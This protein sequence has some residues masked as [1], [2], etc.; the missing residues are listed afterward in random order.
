MTRRVIKAVGLAMGMAGM[1]A[2]AQPSADGA[3]EMVLPGLV[4]TAT[5]T[6]QAPR[7]VPASIDVISGATVRMMGPQVNLSEPLQRIP[8][9]G[10][11]N[12]QNYAQDLQ[13]SSRGFGARSAFGVRGV[14]LYADGIPATMPDGQG[15]SALF[16]L[17]SAERIEVL[18][19]PAS[20]LYGNASGGVVQVFTEDGPPRPEVSTGLTVSRDGFHREQIKLGGEL[21]ALNYVINASH[22]ETDGYRDHSSAQRDQ[23]NTKL[24]WSFADRATLSVVASY[25]NM[26]EVEDPLGLTAEQWRTAPSS[27]VPNA[28]LYNTRKSIENAQLG[29]VYQRPMRGGDDT[30]M[31]MVYHG[32]RQVRQY[33]SIPAGS[34][35]GSH[36]GGVIDFS[37][38]YAG[39]DARYT[40][41]H[42]AL[43]RP[44]EITAGV[45]LDEMREDRQGYR[46]FVDDGGGEATLGVLGERR[47]DEDNIAR[48]SD[49]YLQ[50]Q[51][52]VSDRWVLSAGVRHSRVRFES[53]D[54]FISGDNGDDSGQALWSATTPTVSALFKLSP[55]WHWYATAGRSFE[56]PTLNETAYRSVNGSQP[57]LNF[58]LRPSTAEH[59]ELGFKAE[60]SEGW[61]LSA[62]A[63]QVDTDDEIGVSSSE[64]GRTVYRNVGR[65]SRHGLEMTAQW[66]VNR[67][68]TAYA[69]LSWLSAHYQ[70]AFGA[71][72]AAVRAGNTLP[73]LPV[74][75]AFA[76]LAWRPATSWHAALELRHSSRVWANDA[77]TEYAPAWTTWAARAGWRHISGDWRLDTLARIDNLNNERYVGS[78]IVNDRSSRY[79]EPAPGRALTV[80]ATLTRAF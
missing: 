4:V 71:G 58:A 24:R 67:A 5:R 32:T 7:D 54:H 43:S 37:R 30:L 77:N 64:Q 61:Q 2:Q 62:A 48:N 21:G 31:A 68:W 33:Q 39:L 27:V 76:E 23:I 15:Q 12:R 69:A 36:P 34:Q 42:T 41:R 18:R 38:Q 53:Q 75:T 65:T 47:R 52:A 28:T 22:F 50:A 80:S 72:E 66:R 26:P 56:T 40:W 29:L 45:N 13:I 60:P 79:Y 20:A 49:Q 70:D 35:V 8:G 11:L 74:R 57:G 51:W 19:G 1:A 44:L 9:L 59:L 17:G 3:G 73:G 46:N 16:D 55:R 10:V 14:R 78:V 63:F 6:P 25:L